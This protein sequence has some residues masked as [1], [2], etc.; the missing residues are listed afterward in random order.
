MKYFFMIIL[1]SIS[2]YS[3]DPDCL[4]ELNKETIRKFHCFPML[5]NNHTFLDTCTF[6]PC[7]Y[8]YLYSGID[9]FPL[10]DLYR[11][12]KM[13]FFMRIFNFAENPF[14]DTTSEFELSAMNDF[15]FEVKDVWEEFEKRFSTKVYFR[16]LESNSKV[17]ESGNETNEKR[18]YSYETR[19]EDLMH[20]DT[21][22]NFFAISF[23]DKFSAN[24]YCRFVHRIRNPIDVLTNVIDLDKSFNLQDNA[25][26]I[27]YN[28]Y[29]QA[30]FEGKYYEFEAKSNSGYFLVKDTKTNK[31]Y[32]IIKND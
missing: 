24:Y 2:S 10:M 27:V 20:K 26:V 31:I 17:D 28:Y 30:V 8:D 21:L 9:P 19:F 13:I 14:P 18:D 5:I 29:G 7:E 22:D 15:Y 25:T 23:K 12:D 16:Y 4:V 6:K 1:L 11:K 3:Y 32:K